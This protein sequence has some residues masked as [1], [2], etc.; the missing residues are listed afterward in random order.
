MGWKTRVAGAFVGTLGPDELWEFSGK[1]V[2]H[3]LTR[4]TPAERMVYLGKLVEDHLAEI[5]AGLGREER[6]RLMNGLLPLLAQEFPLD[7]L[8]ILGAFSQAE[9]T[10]DERG[11]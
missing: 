4:L 5:L 8:D 6:A 9:V 11:S 3:M 10:T 2:Q 7:E 1:A